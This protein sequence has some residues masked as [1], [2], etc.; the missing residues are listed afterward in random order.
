ML[1]RPDCFLGHTHPLGFYD[2]IMFDLTNSTC[3]DIIN[4][5]SPVRC[6]WNGAGSTMCGMRNPLPPGGS[7]FNFQDPLPVVAGQ[8]IVLA[9]SNYSYTN[10]GYTLDFSGST[11]GIG[12]SPIIN[13][14]GASNNPH[15]Q[16]EQIGQDVI[17][18]HAVSLPIFFPLQYNR[19]FLQIQQFNRSMY[20]V[21]QV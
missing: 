13:W 18:L 5:I 3:N 6:N 9:L 21:V 19:S 17:L 15:G 2:W 7:P 1:I 11:A 4:V 14:T 8:T 20:L 10:G 12:N 16:Q